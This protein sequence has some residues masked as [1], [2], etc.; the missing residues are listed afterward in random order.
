CTPASAGEAPRRAGSPWT[1]QTVCRTFAGPGPAVAARARAKGGCRMSRR[2]SLTAVCFLVAAGASA[3]PSPP[4]TGPHFLDLK[5]HANHKL[6]DN[7]HSDMYPGNN[8]ASLPTGK[9]TF[10]GVKFQVGDGVVQLGSSLVTGKPAKVEG[11]K[12]GRHLAKLHF[13]HATGYSAAD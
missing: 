8:L 5:P 3:A 2:L 9:Q 11:I 10:A 1:T 13:L 7:F 4:R 6:R 12:V